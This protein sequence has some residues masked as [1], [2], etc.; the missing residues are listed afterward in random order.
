MTST[1]A[2]GASAIPSVNDGTRAAADSVA[3]SPSAG[4]SR[5][6]AETLSTVTGA[7]RERRTRSRQGNRIGG[8]D[9][10]LS[11]ASSQSSTPATVGAATIIKPM[12]RIS[13]SRER[14]KVIRVRSETAAARQTRRAQARVPRWR[15]ADERAAAWQSEAARAAEN[16]EAPAKSLGRR[17]GRPARRRGGP[18]VA[19]CPP[20]QGPATLP[21]LRGHR[22]TSIAAPVANASSADNGNAR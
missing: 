20:D 1:S 6:T 8:P 16:R 2:S 18:P 9:R 12:C 11:R 22:G 19:A 3:P 15:K 21:S 13:E 10:P 4:A 5:E 17:I 14:T 7:F